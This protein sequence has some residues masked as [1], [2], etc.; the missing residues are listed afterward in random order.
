MSLSGQSEIK[1][2]ALGES[3]REA[4]VAK[5]LKSAGDSVKVDEVLVEL[6]TDKVTLEV[7]SP[8]SGILTEVRADVGETVAVG[9]LLGF[10][11]KADEESAPQKT[12]EIQASE[13]K[14]PETKAS[15]PKFLAQKPLEPKISSLKTVMSTMMTSGPQKTATPPQKAPE[16]RFPPSVRKLAEELTINPKDVLGTGKGNRVTKG[17]VLGV[18][19]GNSST[20]E[21]SVPVQAPPG[22]STRVSDQREER[23]KMSRLRLRIAERLKEAQNTAAILTTFNEVDMTAINAMRA[24]YKESFEQKHGIRLGV[25]SFFVKACVLALKE[26]PAVN[27]EM[28]GDEIIYKNY[29]DIGV[30]VST[31][32][33][34]VVPI[35]RNADLLSFEEIEREIASLAQKAKDGK[36]TIA[37]MTGG[38]FTI[39]NGGVFGSLLATP[40]LNPPQTGILG[41]HKMQDRPVVIDGKIEIRS[42]MYVALSYD[43]RVIDGR[44]SVT[45]LVRVKEN[46]E[47]PERLML[48]M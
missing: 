21:E 38:T 15:G 39:S 28:E 25:M 19:Q 24:K 42:M 3:I 7:S 40:I 41:M 44:E 20:N 5:W 45:F 13:I 17:D 2:P 18:G 22:Q 9:D 46:L 14:A 48:D 1:V 29:Y 36:L 10:V 47:N 16:E 32:Q 34:L 12:P 43:H 30:A 4:T 37:E 8:T 35:V 11:T 23:V 31:P 27:S 26:F 33:G 6:E